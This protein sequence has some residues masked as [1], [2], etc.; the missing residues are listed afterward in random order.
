MN[1]ELRVVGEACRVITVVTK[2]EVHLVHCN[3]LNQ[4]SELKSVVLVA[5]ICCT[6][7]RSSELNII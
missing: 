1:F 7:E 4:F 6:S 5:T 2:F 3:Q